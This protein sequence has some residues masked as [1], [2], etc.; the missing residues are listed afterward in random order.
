AA[1]RRR[2]ACR[3]VWMQ[4]VLPGILR[5]VK[6]DLVHFTNYLAPVAGRVPYLVSFHD[7]RLTLLPQCHRV[8]KRLLTSSLIP[9]VARGAR[10]ILTPSESTRRDVVRLLR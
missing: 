7:M 4:F 5:D 3:W 1:E 2:F 9:S 8:K 10:M 6:P